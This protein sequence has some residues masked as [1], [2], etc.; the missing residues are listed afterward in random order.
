MA[1]YK[2]HGNCKSTIYNRS[3]T[4]QTKRNQHNGEHISSEPKLEERKDLELEIN[5]IKM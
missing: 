5:V 3:Y 1:I 2:S 4:H